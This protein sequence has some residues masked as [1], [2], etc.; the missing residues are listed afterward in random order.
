M[1]KYQI[2]LV[3]NADYGTDH[4]GL[5][6]NARRSGHD[7]GP[8]SRE[9]QGMKRWLTKI[10]SKA[11]ASL[12]GSLKNSGHEIWMVI[13]IGLLMRQTRCMGPWACKQYLLWAHIW[14]IFGSLGIVCTCRNTWRLAEWQ[15]DDELADGPGAV[16]FGLARPKGLGFRGLGFRGLGF[17]GLE[18]RV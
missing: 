17:R 10:P 14:N 7:I 18:F 3:I 16:V 4:S 9:Q 11:Q 1:P 13:I 5:Y 15:T 8:P 12:L 6:K 2:V